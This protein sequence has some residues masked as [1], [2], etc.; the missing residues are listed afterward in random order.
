MLV[1]EH[2]VGAWHLVSWEVV[3]D[4]RRDEPFGPNATGVITYTAD[5]MMQATIAAA[6]RQPYSGPSARRSP[7]AE[8]ARAARCYFSYAGPWHLDGE[9]VVHDVTHALDPGF[10][11][12]AQRRTVELDG[13]RLVLSAVEPTGD[14]SRLHRL[15]WRRNVAARPG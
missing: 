10:V 7:D 2:L 5:G 13:D 12:T 1:A 6:D 11:G 3:T 14:A 9:V 15:T 8:V 4:G